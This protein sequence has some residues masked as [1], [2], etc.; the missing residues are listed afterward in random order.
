MFINVL[1][2]DIATY[3]N[4]AFSLRTID[5]KFSQ[6]YSSE[7]IKRTVNELKQR[8]YIQ[9]LIRGF[10]YKPRFIKLINEN[11]APD[12]NEVAY[13]IAR[14]RKWIIAPT[15]ERS[16][17][18]LGL[19]RQVS[20]CYIFASTGPYRQYKINNITIAFKRCK[21]NELID[22]CD[23]TRIL[24]QGLKTLGKDNV[25]KDTILQLRKQFNPRIKRIFLKESAGTT[26]WI[27]KCI[28]E[29]CL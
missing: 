29:I 7:T 4:R 24:I 26:A 19:S 13:E 15:G 27:Y 12:Y 11:A 2:K 14:R 6:K 5:N 28:K 9:P 17:N 18:L 3:G 1:K 10:Y 8:G 20:N 25:N 16:L 22:C 21:P 23:E